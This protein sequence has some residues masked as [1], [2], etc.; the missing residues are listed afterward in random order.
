MNTQEQTINA[1]RISSEM[2]I[3]RNYTVVDTTEDCVYAV[4]T[5][6]ENTVCMVVPEQN[7]DI[8][9]GKYI[10][11]FMKDG[12]IKHFI[13]IYGMKITPHAKNALLL[14]TDIEFEM[15]KLLSMQINITKHVLVPR[16][17]RLTDEEQEH[18]KKTYGTCIP[19]LLKTD[20]IA[21]FYNFQKG[22][23]VRV[24][25]KDFCIHRIVK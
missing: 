1:L 15:F 21:L 23:I 8:E 2:M 11:D 10:L 3:Q 24:Y 16:H 6:G 17:E 25:R 19:I 18:Y 5:K 4:N 20:P 9:F 14:R 22:D 12:Q 7:I 13:L